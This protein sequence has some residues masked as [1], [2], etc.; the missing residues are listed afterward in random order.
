MISLMLLSAL[1]VDPDLCVSALSAAP[2]YTECV[3]A[4]EGVGLAKSKAEASALAEFGKVARERFIHHFPSAP[5]PYAVFF[6]EK[7]PPVAQLK[8]AGF[9]SVL[10]WSSPEEIARQL[11]E[12]GLQRAIEMSKRPLPSE[13]ASVARAKIPALVA[14]LKSQQN[15]V[16]AHE[17]GHQWYEEIYWRGRPAPNNGYGTLAP[18]WLDE[19]AAILMEGQDM[20][21]DRR[22]SFRK[23]WATAS[24]DAQLRKNGIGDLAGFLMQTHPTTAEGRGPRTPGVSASVGSQSKSGFYDQARMFADYLMEKTS[25]PAVFSR[26]TRFVAKGGALERWFAEQNAYPELPRSVQALQEDWI[27]W[28]DQPAAAEPAPR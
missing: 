25:D 18:D 1:E 22:K 5:G 7:D 12:S 23:A 24:V 3:A 13:V 19:T 14:K 20:T 10:P 8:A 11:I 6:A 17:L 27:A 9:A 28:L 2:A 4:G 21:A 26:L 16:I 15:D